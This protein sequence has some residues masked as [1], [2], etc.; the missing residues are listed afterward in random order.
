MSPVRN[1]STALVEKYS[2][3]IA[4]KVS[5]PVAGAVSTSCT[6]EAIGVATTSGQ[7]PSSSFAASSASGCEPKNP[8]SAVTKI[9][10]GNSEVRVESAI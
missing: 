2:A 7:T 3:R 5:K 6:S 4:P 10:N 9:R 1:A 8:A